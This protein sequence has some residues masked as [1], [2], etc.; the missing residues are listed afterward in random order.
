VALPVSFIFQDF[1]RSHPLPVFH[2]LF[3]KRDNA[4]LYCQ[5]GINYLD[6]ILTA[7]IYGFQLQ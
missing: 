3:L 4:L 1:W 5:G 2:F 6:K 7:Y